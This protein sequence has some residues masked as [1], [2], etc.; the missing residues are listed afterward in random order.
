[1]NLVTGNAATTFD[2]V[3]VGAGPAG[4]VLANRLSADPSVRVALVDAGA[5]P[6][7][8]EYRMPVLSP[9]LWFNPAATWMLQ[10]QPE[11]ALGGR[12]LPIPAG[13][14]LGGGTAINGMVVNRGLPTDYEAFKDLGLEHWG[15]RELLPYFLRSESSWRGDSDFHETGGPFK[16]GPVTHRSPIVDDALEAARAMGF[17]V[18]DDF[19]GPQ[20]VGFGV[21]D[22][23]II[24]GNRWGTYEAYLAPAMQRDN[25]TV[26]TETTITRIVI[27]SGRATGVEGHRDGEPIAI[28]ADREVI[29]VGGAFRTPHL[30][31]HSGI[32]DPAELEAHGIT[33][34]VPNAEV[35]K[36]LVDQPAV[37]VEIACSPELSHD[38]EMRDDRYAANEARWHATGDGPFANMPVVVTGIA[39]I[40]PAST[41]PDTRFMLGGAADSR[42]WSPS[43][44][45]ERKGDV[46]VANAA[47]SYPHSRG[48][49][50]LASGD[51][52]DAPL[53][54]YNLLQDERDVQA[55]TRGFMALMQFLRQPALARHLG[56]VVRPVSPPETKAELAVFLR[57]AASTTQHPL[58][59]C[60]MGVDPS[61]VVDP[62]LRVRGVEG[63]RVADA[64]VL[65]RQIGGNPTAVITMLGE[66][67]ADLVLGAAPLEPIAGGIVAIEATRAQHGV[68]VLDE[69]PDGDPVAATAPTGDTWETKTGW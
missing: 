1:M 4:C 29:V 52:A 24:G 6:T 19:S 39:T 45:N 7:G 27:E 65:P 16:I 69:L 20:P 11:P 14:V 46:L 35:G 61:S 43:N 22:V 25:L 33:V 56:D 21:P 53:V 54:N 68:P 8:L 64:S 44:P 17:P 67:A 41:E 66:K 36:N 47:V 59:T 5:A 51:P 15:Y 10:S 37:G 34:T 30:L 28:G 58:A 9:S 18:T 63:L 57:Q 12:R 60:R 13:R 2:Y 55:L 40:D 23:N 32:G 31:M 26:F 38:F 48:H 49:V 42:R 62:E 50:R 3:I